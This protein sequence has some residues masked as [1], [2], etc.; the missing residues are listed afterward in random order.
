MSAADLATFAL[1]WVGTY[2]V[3]STLLL[4]GI[5]IFARGRGARAPRLLERLWTFGL[6]AGIATATLQVGLGIDPLGGSWRVTAGAAGAA[7]SPAAALATEPADALPAAPRAASA[8]ERVRTAAEWRAVQAVVILR[9]LA[10]A[11]GISGLRRAEGTTGSLLPPGATRRLP[12]ADLPAKGGRLARLAALPWR[13]GLAAAVL[14][15]AAAGSLAFFAAWIRLELRLRRRTP[16]RSGLAV[17]ILERLR[18]RAGLGAPVRLSTSPS[19]RGP[20]SLGLLRREICLPPRALAAL[21][22]GQIEAMLAHE[23]GHIVRRDAAR[24]SLYALLERLL[25]VQPLNRVA[26]RHLHALAEI[27]CDDLAVRW[28][29]RRLAL[30]SSLAEI[31][32][33]LV[34]ERARGLGAP[35]IVSPRSR[36]AQRIERL[37]DDRRSPRPEGR[38]RWF[39]PCAGAFALLL[40]LAAPGVGAGAAPR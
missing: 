24:F 2:L 3:H 35:A 13:S 9:A 12:P 18:R 15:A 20:V 17:E 30:A 16:L 32:R 31:A 7:T 4:G 38:H 5:W 40:A 36:L 25:A 27:L 6:L 29:G 28:T 1:A 14:I 10:A 37:L 22:P 23:L 8:S 39:P 11:Q 19:L 34:G 26:R 21:E 33:W